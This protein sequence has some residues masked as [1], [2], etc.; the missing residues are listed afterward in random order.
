MGFGR[1]ALVTTAIAFALGPVSSPAHQTSA[2]PKDDGPYSTI[3]DVRANSPAT[4]PSQ[5]VSDEL[6]AT[7]GTDPAYVGI[8]LDGPDRV[9]VVLK[10]VDERTETIA[11]VDVAYVSAKYSLEEL[12]QF[13]D[14]VLAQNP[15]VHGVV[16]KAA[17]QRLEALLPP[18]LRDQPIELVIDGVPVDVPVWHRFEDEEELDAAEGGRH[19]TGNGCTSGFSDERKPNQHSESLR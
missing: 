11:G 13:T 7:H 12:K 18:D 16:V 3:E 15:S 4:E 2:S 9:R 10:G 14:A 19:V 6:M 1:L 8:Y 17:E 5:L